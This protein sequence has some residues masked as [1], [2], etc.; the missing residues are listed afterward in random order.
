MTREISFFYEDK[1]SVAYFFAQTKT[2]KVRAKINCTLGYRFINYN[3]SKT[4]ERKEHI[5]IKMS[6]LEILQYSIYDIVLEN[7][8]GGLFNSWEFEDYEKLT[9]Y[10]RQK[11]IDEMKT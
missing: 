4:N 3:S 1:Q 10:I 11:Y 9:N 5:S 7:K 8:D 6:D 2:A